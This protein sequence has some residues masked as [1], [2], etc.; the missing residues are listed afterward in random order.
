MKIET[1]LENLE[2]FAHHGIYPEEREKGGTFC[3]NVWLIKDVPE[4]KQFK[5]LEEVIDYEKI[6]GIIRD[7]MQKPRDLLE[8]VAKSILDRISA[9]HVNIL[10]IKVKITKYKPGGKFGEGNASV[11]LEKTIFD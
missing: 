11:S 6:Y 3:V 9:D 4:E 1:A 10:S 5:K 8:E 2:F 7:E